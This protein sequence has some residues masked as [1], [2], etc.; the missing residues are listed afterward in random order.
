M[1][2]AAD[3]SYADPYAHPAGRAKK[4]LWTFQSKG[5]PN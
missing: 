5:L 1:K 2:S 4:G 3:R